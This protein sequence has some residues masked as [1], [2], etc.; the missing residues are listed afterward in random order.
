MDLHLGQN[1]YLVVTRRRNN[2]V[3]I[4]LREKPDG[5]F[6]RLGLIQTKM[7]IDCIQVIDSEADKVL[8]TLKLD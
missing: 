1:K 6:I 7:L 3:T 4:D 5:K 2:E 8:N